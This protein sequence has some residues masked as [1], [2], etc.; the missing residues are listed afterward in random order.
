M[1]E[2]EEK[3][4]HFVYC[5]DNLNSAWR[6][7]QKVKIEKGNPLINYAFQ[8]A[9]I[10]YSKPYKL[11]YGVVVKYHQLPETYIPSKYLD[12]HKRILNARDKFHAHSDLSIMDA[13]VYIQNTKNGKFVSRS[14]N[15]VHG[16]EETPNIGNII[17]LIEQTLDA[18][19]VEVKRL[20]Y[21]L[22]TNS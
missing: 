4:L 16:V 21:D 1:N 11:S 5:I 17:D 22:D 6:I 3:Y 13:K 18:L 19:Y 7:L 12:L 8:F 15:I 14:Q 9:L 20:E 2:Q 10:E